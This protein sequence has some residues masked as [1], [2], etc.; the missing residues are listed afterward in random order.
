MR[1]NNK[2][3]LKTEYLVLFPTRSISF[4]FVINRCCGTAL[5]NPL[6]HSRPASL[7]CALGSVLRS[8]F[9]I[10]RCSLPICLVCLVCLSVC[11]SVLSVLF[12]CLPVCLS[13]LP[14][15]LFCL[16]GLSVFFGFL[17]CQ[18]LRIYDGAFLWLRVS[19]LAD[20][21]ALGA[22]G[23]EVRAAREVF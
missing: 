11:L 18:G 22:F 19:P 8:C 20:S 16:S 17:H 21:G 3:S 5:R 1:G 6:K 23:A 4:F 7:M 14:V 13:A 15:C 12:V 10:A 9:V 2:S